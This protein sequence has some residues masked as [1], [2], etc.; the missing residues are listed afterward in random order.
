VELL[1]TGANVDW[2]QNADGLRIELPKQYRPQVDY[3]AALKVT[4]A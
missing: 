4:L 2:K 1:E 3:A